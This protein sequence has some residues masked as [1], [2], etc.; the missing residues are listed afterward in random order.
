[1]ADTAVPRTAFFISS[2]VVA[3]AGTVNVSAAV[4]ELTF[5]A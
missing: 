3:A 5:T 4:A 2:T 1:M